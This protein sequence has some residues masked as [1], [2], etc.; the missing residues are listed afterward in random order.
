[1]NVSDGITPAMVQDFHAGLHETAKLLEEVALKKLKGKV[2]RGSREVLEEV[3]QD[4]RR[5]MRR[6]RP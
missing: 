5:M 4:A 2:S 3:V 6:A 1:M